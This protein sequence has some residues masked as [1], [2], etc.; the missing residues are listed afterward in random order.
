MGKGLQVVYKNN[1]SQYNIAKMNQGE[2]NIFAA[3]IAT[4]KNRGTELIQMD[5]SKFRKIAKIDKNIKD[6]QLQPLVINTLQKVSGTSLV[7]END[8]K[9]IIFPMFDKIVLDKTTKTIT[10]RVSDDFTIYFNNF[11][12]EFT[13]FPLLTFTNISGKY[14]KMLYK[15][16]M[17]F[18]STGLYKC[19][20]D[21]FI[22]EILG[23][24]TTTKRNNINYKIIKPAIE[25]VKLVEPRFKDLEMS[26]AKKA[27][28]TST[29]IFTFT[30]FE[31]DKPQTPNGKSYDEL[32]DEMA[33]M[34]NDKDIVDL[35]DDD[36]P[37]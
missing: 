27:G 13:S 7:V 31:K 23:V 22:Y 4:I 18:A 1:F 32:I 9:S 28:A 15:T 17:T 16:L 6:D 33:S 2:L 14:S 20:Y 24:P 21:K 10:L 8:S 30:P 5:F 36:L 29:I 26:L 37:F 19:D 11:I 12:G 35:Y 25:K 3:L 34:D